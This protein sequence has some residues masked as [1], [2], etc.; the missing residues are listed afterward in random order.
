MSTQSSAQVTV[1]SALNRAWDQGQPVDVLVGG[2]WF[3]GMISA[4]DGMGV[5][6]D[7]DNFERYVIRLD[8]VGAVRL[9]TLASGSGQSGLDPLGLTA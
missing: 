8:Q 2:H 6:I 3:S 1:G 7:G 5:A 9:R 4:V